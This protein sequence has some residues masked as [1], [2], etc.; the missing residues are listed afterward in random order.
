M[1]TPT[2]GLVVFVSEEVSGLTAK[3]PYGAIV[4][5][6]TNASEKLGDQVVQLRENV[7][8]EAQ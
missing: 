3:M 7:P 4:G 6:F 5:M 2:C 1:P 8:F